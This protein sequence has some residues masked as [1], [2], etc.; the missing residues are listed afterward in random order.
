MI[1]AYLFDMDGTLLDTDILWVDLVVDYIHAKGYPEFTYEQSLAIV[2]G[3]CFNDIYADLIGLYPELRLTR[4]EMKEELD[5]LFFPKRDQTDVCIPGSV[6]LLKRLSQTAPC[7]IVSGS[8]RDHIRDAIR[9]M[10]AEKNV[11]AYFGTEDSPRGKP[12][13]ICFLTA[14]RAIGV[15][16]K[17]CVVFEDSAAG[18]AA[19]KAAGMRVVA[20][21]LP[22]HPKQA[23]S[24]AD[25]ILE[26]LGLFTPAMLGE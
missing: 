25:V 17:D 22:G 7:C 12:D 1:A 23:I 19:G 9:I 3:R 15:D 16:P 20:I 11:K 24:A 21:Q 6:A 18:V 2:Y 13:P 8:A 10:D 5:L 4:D 26:D 14:A